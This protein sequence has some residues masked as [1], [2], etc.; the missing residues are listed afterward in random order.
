M[1]RGCASVEA[2]QLQLSESKSRSVADNENSSF[3]PR[4]V[5]VNNAL[6]TLHRELSTTFSSYD[7]VSSLSE[8]STTKR[9]SKNSYC[10]DQ[11]VPDLIALHPSVEVAA[12][13]AYKSGRLILQDKSS[14][15]PGYLL[16]GDPARPWHGDIIDA[17]AA[18]GNKTTHLI[19]LLLNSSVE[20]PR[21]AES[22]VLSFDA[23]D[24]RSKTLK[25][26]V[27]VA[28][29]SQRTVLFPGQDFLSVNPDDA[30]FRNVTAL[31]L[32]P[33]CSG[34]G[35]RGREDIPT[36]ALPADPRASK[37][38]APSQATDR[39]KRKRRDNGDS[40]AALPD[41]TME[42]SRDVVIDVERLTKLSN[43]QTQIVEHAF[44]FPAATRVTYSTCSI[45]EQENENVVSRALSSSIA[46][47]RGWRILR[48][49]DQV[50]GMKTWKRRGVNSSGGNLN[51]ADVERDG[52]IRCSPD[53]EEGTGGF[54]V[55]G[56]VRDGN[57]ENMNNSDIRR[58]DADAD[59]D[60]GDDDDKSWHGFSD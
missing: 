27:D 6:T 43:L 17:C 13:P 8:L 16:L 21:S 1:R 40:N 29:V 23:S 10:V 51:L 50:A 39:R 20:T 57:M 15:F 49:E 18:P 56:F 14:C 48:R 30:R 35:I 22:R 37:S 11:H 52:C 38:S 25:K 46:K 28:G 12:F 24:V 59:A 5:R 3:A 31:L 32:D 54:F 41:V 4:W 55:A 53:D 60:D 42:E 2:L 33:S 9:G 58:S 34:S 44:R 45:H 36:L 26:M 7:R 19:S 47:Q